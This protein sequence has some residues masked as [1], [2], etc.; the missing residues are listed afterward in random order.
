MPPPAPPTSLFRIYIAERSRD[1]ALFPV[2][3]TA[4]G[5]AIGKP[6]KI[7]KNQKK[8]SVVRAAVARLFPLSHHAS[9]CVARLYPLSAARTAESDTEPDP[10]KI[11]W[12][13]GWQSVGA[14]VPCE[15]LAISLAVPAPALQLPYPDPPPGLSP[16][17]PRSFLGGSRCVRG[18][19]MR[20]DSPAMVPLNLSHL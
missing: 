16:A 15:S 17:C 19:H 1:T 13:F 11:G 2:C 6:K 18:C 5:R 14:M 10:E 3:S 9:Q 12:S 7:T 8:D 4:H 20:L